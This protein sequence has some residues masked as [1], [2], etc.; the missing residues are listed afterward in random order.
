MK[1]RFI[2]A[3]AAA[4]TLLT[5]SFVVSAQAEPNPAP[6]GADLGAAVATAADE[7]PTP[8]EKSGGASWTTHPQSLRYLRS[9]DAASDRVKVSNVGKTVEG[10]AIQL[11]AVG[12]P[13]PKTVEEAADGSVA[14]FVCSVHGDE[15]S[16]R[17]ACLQ[18]ARDLALSTDA[19]V[20][21]FLE[22]TTVLFV[23]ANPDGWVADTRGNADGTDVNRDYLAGATPEAAT[24]LKLIRDWKPD[25][26]NDLHEYGPGEHYETDLLHLWPRNRNV[27]PGTYALAKQMSQDYASAQVT[28]LGY[29]S[30]VYGQLIKDGEPYQQVAGDGQGR[31]LR[32]YAGLVNVVGMLSE[33]ANEPLND[34][35]EA[36]PSLLNRRRVT[37]NYHSAVGSIEMVQDNRDRLIEETAAAA[38]RQ[39]KAGADR[40]GVIYFG[41]QDDMLPTAA[42]QVEAHPMC[43]Y[44][45]ST[46]QYD[47]LKAT[48]ALHGIEAT[49]TDGGRQVSLAQPTRG[50]I[51]LLLD[52][53]SEYGLTDAT[54]LETC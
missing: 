37:V 15:P 4:A 43:G 26:L 19:G 10:R 16:G 7:L 40:S 35:E 12:A 2:V 42:N 6:G 54:P 18:L 47:K 50:L 14:M 53:R 52:A 38:E 49:P 33:T 22:R 45:L 13:A 36:D 9:L 29:T 28:S 3:A 25:T 34:E 32:N 51:P 39:S 44:Q 46:A 23:N 20:V 24:V 48:L 41:G 31:I 17:E 27:D 30:G 5:T 21:D 1:R 8:F 11:V